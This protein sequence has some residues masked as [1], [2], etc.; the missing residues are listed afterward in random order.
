MYS[1]DIWTGNSNPRQ[2]LIFHLSLLISRDKENFAKEASTAIL[3]RPLVALNIIK[4]P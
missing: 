4:L 3:A 1:N 2:F